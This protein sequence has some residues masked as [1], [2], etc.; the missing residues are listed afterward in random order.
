[1]KVVETLV[2]QWEVGEVGGKHLGLPGWAQVK[3]G[4]RRM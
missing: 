3:R 1:M 4:E 2:L